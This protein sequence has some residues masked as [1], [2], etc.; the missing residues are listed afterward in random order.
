MTS[1]I[2][3]MTT[4][5]TNMSTSITMSTVRT[6]PAAAMTTSMS[7]TTT[8]T[9]STIITTTTATA[10]AVTIMTTTLTRCSPPGARKRPTK[11]TEAELTAAL[12]ALGDVTLGTVL[13]AKGIVPCADGGEWLH[14]D[15]V[16]GAPEI[17]RG[18]ADYTG[19]LCVIGSELDEERIASLF[20]V[21]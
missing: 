4:M 2:T 12:T 18:S 17:R 5:S 10:V 21:N 15:Y 3:I 16:P 14:F 7:I 9:T 11:Y 19:R 13:R 20:G 6:A 1:T 8:M